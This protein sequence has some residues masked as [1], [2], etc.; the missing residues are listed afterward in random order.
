[1][2]E[3]WRDIPCY[4]G[5]YQASTFGN[6]KRLYK[7][8]KEKILK[9]SLKTNGYLI[10][11]LSKNNTRKSFDVHRLVAQVFIPNTENKSQVNHK[12]GIKTDNRVENLEWITPLENMSHAVSMGLTAQGEKNRLAK[13]SNELAKFIRENPDNLTGR[14][15]ASMFNLK[16]QSITQIQ[17][18]K[19]FKNAGGIIRQAAPQKERVPDSIRAQIRSEYIKRS[20]NFNCYTLAEKYGVCPQ[21]IWRI[22]NQ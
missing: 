1:M 16:P 17:T 2:V 11:S 3:Q 20:G 14:Q 18:G 8:G 13:I 12:N 6:I 10:V 7:S 5:F 15:L 19:T 22:I 9:P 21:T 4:E